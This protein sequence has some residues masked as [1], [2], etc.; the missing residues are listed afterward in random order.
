M[1]LLKVKWK[2]KKYRVDKKWWEDGYEKVTLRT[3]VGDAYERKGN[4]NIPSKHENTQGY[5]GYEWF[6]VPKSEVTVVE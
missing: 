4:S 5:F 1:K 3:K 6:V 2:G